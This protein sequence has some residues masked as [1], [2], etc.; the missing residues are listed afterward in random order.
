ML[1]YADVFLDFFFIDMLV[2]EMVTNESYEHTEYVSNQDLEYLMK[3]LHLECIILNKIFYDVS[4][5]LWIYWFK[6]CEY[7]QVYYI[8]KG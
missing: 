4:S 5:G 6:F 7:Q 1:R 3:I 8:N 2:F